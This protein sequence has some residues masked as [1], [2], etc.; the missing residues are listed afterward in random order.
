MDAFVLLS[1]MIAPHG[2]PFSKIVESTSDGPWIVTNSLQ[3][4]LGGGGECIL[5]PPPHIKVV[6]QLILGTFSSVHTIMRTLC[7]HTD[8]LAPPP[9]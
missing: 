4:K 9:G 2:P 1:G 8:R 6:G 5:P 7:S 3:Q